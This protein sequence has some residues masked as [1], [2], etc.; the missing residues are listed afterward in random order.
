MPVFVFCVD[1]SEN[2]M[3]LYGKPYYKGRLLCIK[4]LY[5][6]PSSIGQGGIV[7]NNTFNLKV[8]ILASTFLG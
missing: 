1:H 2:A 4:S 3:Y 5:I 7:S 6:T 8:C